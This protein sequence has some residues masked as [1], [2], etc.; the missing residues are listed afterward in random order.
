MASADIHSTSS[1]LFDRATD[2]AALRAAWAH[3]R[4]S[5]ERSASRA[6]RADARRFDEDA[7]R[8]LARISADLRAER[9]VFAPARGIAAARPGKRPRPIV[10]APLESR[11]VARALLDALQSDPRVAEAFVGAQTTFG[12]VPGRGV[13]QAIVAAIA[14]IREGATFYARSDIADFF[15]NIPR[16]RAVAAIA[17]L[18]PDERVRR[19]LDQATRTELENAAALGDSAAL[20]PGEA[21]G[22]AQGS[23]LSTLLGN[24]LLRDFDRAMNGRGIACLRYVDDL[25]FL[26]PRAAH[27]RRAF[28]SASRALADLGLALYDPAERPDK[29]A[30]GHVQGGVEWLGCEIASGRARPSAA[31]RRALLAHVERI[32]RDS[33]RTVGGATV[34]ISTVDEL[35]AGFRGAY[36]F[37]ATP[38]VLAALDAQIGRR[39]ERYFRESRPRLV[40]TG[41]RSSRTALGR[42]AG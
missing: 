1:S 34:A 25:L 29:A 21:I 14:A 28:S 15:R 40:D 33:E 42:S 19:L 3:V 38:D 23:S 18:V 6:I 31:A 22:V 27:V 17:A 7:D 36:G 5:A 37:C 9:F 13:E 32:L 24:V 12:G 26:G 10:I 4:R 39:L 30:I 35:L 41:P 16:A 8:A 2:P 11:V 20:F